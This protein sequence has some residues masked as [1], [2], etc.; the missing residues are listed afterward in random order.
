MHVS[1]NDGATTAQESAA[2][3]KPLTRVYGN[4]R[5]LS[6]W[7]GVESIFQDVQDAYAVIVHSFKRSHSPLVQVPVFH[8]F[9]K[10]GTT[11]PK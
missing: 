4:T 2:A 9:C 10:L 5:S 7:E 3:L 8:Q 11:R 6:D 1:T